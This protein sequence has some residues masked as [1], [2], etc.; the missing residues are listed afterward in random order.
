MVT[1]QTGNY[2]LIGTFNNSAYNGNQ[3]VYTFNGTTL[4]NFNLKNELTREI[5]F[6]ADLQVL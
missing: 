4:P 3:Q 5:E 6:G 1:N 2:G